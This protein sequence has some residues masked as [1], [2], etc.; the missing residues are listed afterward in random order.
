MVRLARR[1]RRL[2]TDLGPVPNVIAESL[3]ALGA[4]G[5]P[6]DPYGGPLAAFLSVVIGAEPDVK[7][8]TV[9]RET[10]TI[11]RDARWHRNVTV[12]CPA[13]VSLFTQAFHAGRYPALVRRARGK[14]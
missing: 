7:S 10:V 14:R 11:V 12:S 4:K 9:N 1:V 2:L 8:V 13:A 5:E 3:T 6:G